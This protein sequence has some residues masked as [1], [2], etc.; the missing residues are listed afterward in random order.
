VSL[1]GHV[2]GAARAE[3]FADPTSHGKEITTGEMD[4]SCQGEPCNP[5]RAATGNSISRDPRA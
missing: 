4:A 3:L 5:N 2:S 1:G